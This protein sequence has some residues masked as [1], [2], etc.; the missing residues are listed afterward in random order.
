M[1]EGVKGKGRYR[2]PRDALARQAQREHVCAAVRPGS[3][4]Q[5]RSPHVRAA[6]SRHLEGDEHGQRG[7]RRGHPRTEALKVVV[8]LDLAT[9]T[10]PLQNSPMAGVCL[11]HEWE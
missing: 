4:P 11:P 6:D 1:K 8:P 2:V 10:K 3:G 7:A 9:L 5:Q